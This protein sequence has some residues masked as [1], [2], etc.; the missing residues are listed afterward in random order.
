MLGGHV[1]DFLDGRDV[2][3]HGIDRLE[4]DDL[5]PVAVIGAEQ[6]VQFG[7][8]VVLEN[9]LF[10]ARVDDSFDHR[11]VVLLVGEQHAI[12][13]QLAQG[14]ESAVMLAVHPEPKIRAA[15]VPCRSASS[16]SSS[17]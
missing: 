7:H 14:A 6:P 11:V 2:A 10:G 15:S 5:G 9:L 17:T 8:V 3:V 12:G 13:H 1:E 4:G 16:C